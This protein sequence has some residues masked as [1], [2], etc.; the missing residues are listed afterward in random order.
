M[1]LHRRQAGKSRFDP[2]RSSLSN[3][4]FMNM[5]GI[6]MNLAEKCRNANRFWV[7]KIE[8]SV[9]TSGRMAPMCIEDGHHGACSEDVYVSDQVEGAGAPLSIMQV[10]ELAWE[11]DAPDQ[12]VMALLAGHD[13]FVAAMEG[14]F[15]FKQAD[16]LVRSLGLR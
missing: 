13:P 16:A 14:G 7:S 12:V 2:A 10:E 15:S 4:L 8:T 6:C 9:V 1:R 3:Y 5:T 11:L